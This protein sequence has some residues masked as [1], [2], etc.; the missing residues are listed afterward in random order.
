MAIGP[1]WNRIRYTLYAPVYDWA[2][3]RLAVFRRG[4][5]RAFELARLRPGERVLLVASGTGLDLEFIPAGVDVT[6]IDITPAM[7]VR[8]KRRAWRLAIPIEAR[9]MDAAALEFPDESFDCV[10]LHLTL[11][12]VPDP[13]ATIREAARILVPGG[14]VSV[15]DKFLPDG[16]TAS[17][18][19][20]A[21][22]A[23]AG[24]LATELNRQLGPLVD[25]AELRLARRE[26]VGLNGAF[27]VARLEKPDPR[28]MDDACRARDDDPRM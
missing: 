25:V 10:V 4:R 1:A 24:I 14:R 3:R 26:P 11:A 12:V 20:R 27:V 23:V 22:S 17:A 21:A 6:A 28:R 5:R 15:F 9:V 7:V 18:G 16:A 8:T 19:R 2:L 13:V